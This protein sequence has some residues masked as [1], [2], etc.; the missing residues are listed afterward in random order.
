[1][2]SNPI[3]IYYWLTPVFW[4][5]DELGG[6]N[7]RTAALDGHPWWKALYYL[8]CLAIPIVAHYRPSWIARLGIAETGSN[9]GLLVLGVVLPYYTF[10]DRTL[11]RDIPLEPPLTLE[12][13]ANFALSAAVLTL[14]LKIQLFWKSPRPFS[15]D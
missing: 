4:L 2:L 6:P 8:F 7:V 5:L 13:M 11:S 3:L 10:I 15:I 9:L 14:S 12:S 1:M